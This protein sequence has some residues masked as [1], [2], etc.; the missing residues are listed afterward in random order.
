MVHL[1]SLIYIFYGVWTLVSFFVN[2]SFTLYVTEATSLFLGHRGGE[3]D[4]EGGWGM[5]V[6]GW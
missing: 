2:G 6:V 1:I 3:G 5:W 4:G